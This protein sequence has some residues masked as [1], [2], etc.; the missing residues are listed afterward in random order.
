MYPGSCVVLSNGGV[1]SMISRASLRTRWATEIIAGT[2]AIAVARP[3]QVL[4][5]CEM[6][7]IFASSSIYEPKRITVVIVRTNVPVPVPRI[8]F[9][10]LR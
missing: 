1:R 4:Q 10:R 8:R 5:L 6:E 7:S 2:R 3:R 9:D